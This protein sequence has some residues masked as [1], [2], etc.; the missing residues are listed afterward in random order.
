MVTDFFIFLFFRGGFRHPRVAVPTWRRLIGGIG[1]RA[2]KW[3]FVLRARP[4]PIQAPFEASGRAKCK[5]QGR[6]QCCRLRLV[7]RV[8]KRLAGLLLYVRY[9]SYRV[10]RSIYQFKCTYCLF[11]YLFIH[12]VNPFFWLF[13]MLV[14]LFCFFPFYFYPS[15]SASASVQS[16]PLFGLRRLLS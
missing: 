8:S 6:V 16:I 4:M 5:L 11:I 7:A 10:S 2:G 9:V 13:F 3:I 15:V 12:C 1:R 14:F